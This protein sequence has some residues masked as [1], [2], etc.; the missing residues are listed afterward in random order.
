MTRRKSAFSTKFAVPMH[1]DERQKLYAAA[2]L[3]QRDALLWARSV[4][5]AAANQI[6]QRNSARAQ[7][8]SEH[9]RFITSTEGQPR[10]F[11]DHNGVEF[12]ENG[13]LVYVDGQLMNPDGSTVTD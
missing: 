9:K 2:E 7:Q 3:D 11:T 6:L 10:T 1:E 4:L 13:Q 5:L 8:I 12:Y